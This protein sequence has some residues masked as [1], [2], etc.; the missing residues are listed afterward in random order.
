MSVHLVNNGSGDGGKRVGPPV[1]ASFCEC[2]GS[3]CVCVRP[4]QP[5]EADGA[6]EEDGVEQN[7]AESQPAV[8]PPAVQMDTQDLRRGWT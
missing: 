3:V 5:L 1:C 7:E 2:V 4:L 6:E 8:Q